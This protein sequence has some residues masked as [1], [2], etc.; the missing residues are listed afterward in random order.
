MDGGGS[1]FESR[2]PFGACGFDPRPLRLIPVRLAAGHRVLVPGSEVRFL[3]G[4]LGVRTP[5]DTRKPCV[6]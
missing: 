2:V 6:S 1:D 4:E 3:D 5:V